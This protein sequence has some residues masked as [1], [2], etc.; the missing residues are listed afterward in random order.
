V[1]VRAI[2]AN[3]QLYDPPE[4]VLAVAFMCLSLMECYLQEDVEGV[5]PGCQKLAAVLLVADTTDMG[6][7][8]TTPPPPAEVA[9]QPPPPVHSYVAVTTQVNTPTPPRPQTTHSASQTDPPQQPPPTNSH[10]GYGDHHGLPSTASL[11]FTPLHP[12]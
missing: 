7:Q 2:K 8:T 9:L 12:G 6:V 4:G 5:N 10:S 11:R 1:M 3:Q